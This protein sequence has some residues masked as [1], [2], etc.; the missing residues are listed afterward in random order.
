MRPWALLPAGVFWMSVRVYA[1]LTCTVMELRGV[2]VK[3]PRTPAFF[4]SSRG[5][6]PWLSPYSPDTKYWSV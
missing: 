1:E 2:N 4:S 5:M 6:T 3:L